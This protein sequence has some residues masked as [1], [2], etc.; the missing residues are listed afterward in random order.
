EK[1]APANLRLRPVSRLNSI[2]KSDRVPIENSFNLFRR[3][4]KSFHATLLRP[5]NRLRTRLELLRNAYARMQQYL[6]NSMP[7]KR[8]STEPSPRPQMN[9]ANARPSAERCKP[10][11]PA[12]NL[13]LTNNW[14]RNSSDSKC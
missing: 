11:S 14:P 12:R 6:L 2:L 5:R 8:L 10:H 13:P 7:S 9:K 3:T 4:L 1:S